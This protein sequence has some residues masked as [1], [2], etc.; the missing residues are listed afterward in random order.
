M[1]DEEGMHAKNSDFWRGKWVIKTTILLSKFVGLLVF[2][3]RDTS[4]CGLPDYL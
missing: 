3:V 4:V 2:V 1:V